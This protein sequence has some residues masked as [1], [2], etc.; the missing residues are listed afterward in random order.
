MATRIVES[1]FA[2]HGYELYDLAYASRRVQQAQTPGMGVLNNRA[3][4]NRV[5]LTDMAEVATMRVAA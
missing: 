5:M 4:R 2:Q 3:K 1:V